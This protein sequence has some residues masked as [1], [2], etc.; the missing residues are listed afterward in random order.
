[1]VRVV[2]E[3]TGELI[4]Y[5]TDLP[6]QFEK[7]VYDWPFRAWRHPNGTLRNYPA[8][9]SGGPTMKRPPSIEI[10]LRVHNN[11]TGEGEVLVPRNLLDFMQ[12]H[13]GLRATPSE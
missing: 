8:V 13:T 10:R 7:G 4:G 1:M 12:N 5:L 6:G 11:S 2:R 3:D 9:P